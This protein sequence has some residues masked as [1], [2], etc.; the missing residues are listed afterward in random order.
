MFIYIYIYLFGRSALST[1]RNDILPT[2][3]RA[4]LEDKQKPVI[5]IHKL[6]IHRQTYS[7]ENRRKM[8]SKLEIYLNKYGE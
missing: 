2:S 5:C 6:H 4:F 8:T 3:P 1:E 7:C